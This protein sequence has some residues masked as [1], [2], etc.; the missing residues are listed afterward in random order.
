M[1]K[2]HHYQDLYYRASTD[3]WLH[4]CLF[5]WECWVNKDQDNGFT[6]ARKEYEHHPDCHVKGKF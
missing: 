6:L 2:K 5:C 3:Q 4:R 1:K